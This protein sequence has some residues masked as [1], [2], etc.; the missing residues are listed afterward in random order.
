MK[1]DV[2]RTVVKGL[3]MEMKWNITMLNMENCL[4]S[5][6]PVFINILLDLLRRYASR[7]VKERSSTL[8][9]SRDMF[10]L[11]SLLPTSVLVHVD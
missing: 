6:M 5:V 8:S 10:E 7:N 9:S 11:L 2:F 1:V 3:E 4:S